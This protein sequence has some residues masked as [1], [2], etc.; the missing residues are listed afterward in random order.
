MCYRRPVTVFLIALT[1]TFRSCSVSL[2]SSG[3][4]GVGAGLFGHGVPIILL[5]RLLVGQS[6]PRLHCPDS[7]GEFFEVVIVIRDGLPAGVDYEKVVHPAPAGDPQFVSPLDQRPVDAGDQG[8]PV[9]Q[10]DDW[11]L[12]HRRDSFISSVTSV[13]T[14]VGRLTVIY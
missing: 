2:G 8:A 13:P 7:A 14:F 12:R 4:G 9:H 6:F 1:T 3:S 11:L 5:T 10:N